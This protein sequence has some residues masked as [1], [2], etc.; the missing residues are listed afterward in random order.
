MKKSI[1]I[2]GF[3]L[4]LLAA[5]SG[6]L[7]SFSPEP[8]HEGAQ[9]ASPAVSAYLSVDGLY[10]HKEITVH[11][12]D[13]VLMVLEEAYAADPAVRLRSKE[14]SGLGTLVTGIGGLENGTE[15]KYW[16]YRVNGAVP[17]VGAGSYLV[18]EGDDIEWFFATSNQ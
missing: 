10:E 4:V 7:W 11:P 13:T 5:F 12:G 16:Q 3:T 18:A 8:S 1:W 17:Q 6:V 14:Y 15:G 9:E 2:L